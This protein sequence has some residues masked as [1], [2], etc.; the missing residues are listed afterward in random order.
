MYNGKIVELGK[1]E[2]VIK[3]PE[4]SY[5]KALLAAVPIPN[6]KVKRE[7]IKR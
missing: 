4:H 1:A 7:R 2:A 3:N 6:P 5:T